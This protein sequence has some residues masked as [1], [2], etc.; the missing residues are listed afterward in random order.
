[1][2]PHPLLAAVCFAALSSLALGVPSGTLSASPSEPTIAPGA[3]GTTQ[4]RWQAREVS[5][6][7]LWVQ[8]ED[9]TQR[10]VA[11]QRDGSV[12]VPWIQPG[13]GY[14][15]L[16][17]AGRSRSQLLARIRVLGVPAQGGVLTASSLQVSVPVGGRGRTTLAWASD[18][19]ASAELW[20]R[21][22]QGTEVLVSRNAR[23]ELTLPWI[24]VA[25]YRFS[26]YTSGRA[27]LLDRLV[28]EGRRS[29]PTPTPPT[30]PP[31]VPGPAGQDRLA[32]LYRALASDT[33][34]DTTQKTLIQARL[35]LDAPQWVLLHSDGRVFASASGS[36]ATVQIH[37][38]GRPVGTRGVIDWRGSRSPVQYGIN[39]L[40]AELLPAGEH[41]VS[42]VGQAEAGAFTFGAGGNL[43][44]LVRPAEHVQ[45]STLSRDS[46]RLSF[47]TRGLGFEKLGYLNRL[48]H[49]ALLTHTLR[50]QRGEALFALAS[51]HVFHNRRRYGDAMWGLFLDGRWDFADRGVRT[52]MSVT[53]IWD[54]ASLRASLFSQAYVEGSRFDGS[55]RTLSLD[56]CEFP[57]SPNRE[58]ELEFQVG[59]TS[60]LVT[61]H[62]G[63]QV[64]GTAPVLPQF[65]QGDYIVVG[66]SR[67][68]Q[69]APL[70][71]P[72]LLAQGAL[73]V[74]A[75]HDGVVFLTAKARVQG[76]SS[77][78]GGTVTLWIEIDGVRRGCIAVQQLRS[79][80]SVSQRTI[81]ASYLAAGQERL[82]PGAHVVRLYARAVGDFKHLS[83]HNDCGVIFF[84]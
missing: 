21:R 56:A 48:P 43:S 64:A 14:Q 54:G 70:G 17:F 55:P 76:D 51:G 75:G 61:L 24:V 57:W 15:F 7:Q 18:L 60:G 31:T 77:D 46:S 63:M 84:D 25:R 8:L 3:R 37:V 69:R 40:A 39:A 4:L 52:N 65:E 71:Q 74:P 1:M 67:T 6:A 81:S 34:V 13:K 19:P 20:V 47:A 78:P 26:L 30:S 53:D 82:R 83:V 59:A 41:T 22:G 33:R 35:R 36:S 68:P 49:R 12:N 73:S 80:A 44:A 29:T 79:P 28:V 50:P 66:G 45:A 11:Q 23:G 58:P 72:R 38:N 16:L 62:G 5:T 2:T 32:S 42:L 10:L 9:G 27:R